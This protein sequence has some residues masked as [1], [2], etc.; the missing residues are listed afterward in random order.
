LRNLKEVNVLG[1]NT[2]VNASLVAVEKLS[3]FL[4][5]VGE[6]LLVLLKCCLEFH[7]S[8]GNDFCSLICKVVVLLIDLLLSFN[9]I[10]ISIF[11]FLSVLRLEL[12]VCDSEVAT[13][14]SYARFIDEEFNVT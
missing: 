13:A 1:V 2:I 14:V 5:E 12:R 7:G 10:L 4:D 11:N 8:R 9:E 3:L 6:V